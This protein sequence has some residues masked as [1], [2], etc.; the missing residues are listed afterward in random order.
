MCPNGPSAALLIRDYRSGDSI[1]EIT[2]LLHDAYADL[3]RAG[4]RY[5]ATH[6]S[7]EV[8]ERRLARGFPLVAEQGGRLVGTV[9]LY[10]P[11]PDHMVAWYRNPNV[12][13]FGQFGVSPELQK[14]G[15]GLRLL[16]AVEAGARDRGAAEIACDT[17]E[18]AEHL[19]A[20]YTREGYRFIEQMDWPETN[21][22]SVVLSK[23]L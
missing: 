12:Y 11:R 17:A 19:R 10:P 7:D 21:Y 14:Q 8:T 20:W 5:L 2:R 16:Q 15:I 22:V 6:Q 1:A 18:G 4:F 13:Y 9:T 23:R 3:A